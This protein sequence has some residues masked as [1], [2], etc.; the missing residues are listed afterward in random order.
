LR[1]AAVEGKPA[2]NA[3]PPKEA[4]AKST[5]PKPKPRQREPEK[6]PDQEE[7]L[8]R[9]DK[10]GTSNAER[11]INREADNAI[12]IEQRKL[13]RIDEALE[14][15]RR[16]GDTVME[17][18]L[19][20]SRRGILENIDDINV[21]RSTRLEKVGTYEKKSRDAKGTG[22][23]A[24]QQTSKE[25]RQAKRAVAK[26]R[27]EA[28]SA[29]TQINER[30]ARSTEKAKARLEDARQTLDDAFR[31][32]LDDIA[33]KRLTRT[34]A[35]AE[36]ALDTQGEAI[37]QTEALIKTIRE[38][39]QDVD[40]SEVKPIQ[41]EIRNLQKELRSARKQYGDL[42]AKV[43]KYRKAAQYYKEGRPQDARRTYLSTRPRKKVESIKPVGRSTEWGDKTAHALNR[44]TLP[45]GHR[46][47][48]ESVDK[49]WNE[50]AARQIKRLNS[51]IAE[52]KADQISQHREFNRLRRRRNRDTAA[53][54]AN[55]GDRAATTQRLKEAQRDLKT[56]QTE[57]ERIRSGGRA[58]AD[59]TPQRIKMKPNAGKAVAGQKK[60]PKQRAVEGPPEHLLKSHEKNFKQYV[61]MSIG[62]GVSQNDYR[63]IIASR[64]IVDAIDRLTQFT[65]RVRHIAKGRSQEESGIFKKLSR[66][67]DDWKKFEQSNLLAE[68]KTLD[69]EA[70][71]AAFRTKTNETLF[72]AGMEIENILRH[73]E[74]FS[75][76]PQQR[77]ELE[78]I[79]SRI[80]A[81]KGVRDA[82]GKAIGNYYLR[83]L[84]PG[85]AGA[86]LDQTA[87]EEDSTGL[88]AGVAITL[89][90]LGYA[91]RSQI[92]DL[93]HRI[94]DVMSAE[95]KLAKKIIK[96]PS[97]KTKNFIN[98]RWRLGIR[99]GADVTD[100]STIAGKHAAPENL[101]E[102]LDAAQSRPVPDG[103]ISAPEQEASVRLFADVLH[104]ADPDAVKAM[105]SQGPAK[106]SDSLYDRV[107]EI[108]QERI[109]PGSPIGRI[110]RYF[111]YGLGKPQ[112]Y[113]DARR[114]ARGAMAM[115][116]R[117]IT[118][119][120]ESLEWAYDAKGNRV[121]RWNKAEKDMLWRLM[122]G[123]KVTTPLAN[124]AELEKISLTARKMFDQAG[125]W[126]TDLG[127]LSKAKFQ[128]NK[129]K[130][131]T[132]LWAEVEAQKLG[133]GKD[134]VTSITGGHP[135]RIL[136]T[137]SMKRGDEAELSKRL[138]KIT[139]PA[140]PTYAGLRSIMSDVV[141]GTFFKAVASESAWAM[142]KPTYQVL[143]RVASN[144]LGQ[145]SKGDKESLRWLR[146]NGHV[147]Y[148]RFNNAK[149]TEKG[150]R[151]LDRTSRAR[152]FDEHGVSGRRGRSKTF[153]A[154][155]RNTFGHLNGMVV[156]DGIAEDLQM[157]DDFY[158][159]GWL[160]ETYGNFLH[161]WKWGRILINPATH[162]RNMMSNMILS[163]LGGMSPADPRS[164]RA[165]KESA[166]MIY[167]DTG[168][169]IYKRAI[170]KGLIRQGN[171]SGLNTEQR[172]FFANT[173]MR[174]GNPW[175][176]GAL[177][178][179]AGIE[180][181]YQAEE[182]LMKLA[183]V[184]H[185]HLNKGMAVDDAI[186][187]ARRS[188]FDYSEIPP[189]VQFMRKGWSPF[190]TFNYKA[191]PRVMETAV[192]HP[193]RLGKWIALFGTIQA[194]ARD[195]F[196]GMDHGETYA[197]EGDDWRAWENEVKPEYL[198]N[199]KIAGVPLFDK[200]LKLPFID[201][202]GRSQYLDLQFILPWGDFT[203]G[204][205]GKGGLANL[206]IPEDSKLA[207]LRHLPGWIQPQFPFV[208]EAAE[209]LMNKSLFTGQPI[210]KEGDPAK[211]K[212]MFDYLW[213]SVL[214]SI[215]PFNPINFFASD[216]ANKPSGI[217]A[218]KQ[219]DVATAMASIFRDGGYSYNKFV[220]G[221]EKIP[222]YRGRTRT[223]AA[224]L[225]DI[226][227]GIKTTPVDVHDRT[228]MLIS[229]HQWAIRDLKGQL[230]SIQRNQKWTSGQRSA[231]EKEIREQI[232]KHQQYIN[233]ISRFA[234]TIAKN[235]SQ[236]K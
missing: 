205:D 226:M 184:R 144:G 219:G 196:G 127:F 137:R 204:L 79:L 108:I 23:P 71:V 232:Q 17:N 43:T 66:M 103:R 35:V 189:V 213:R 152:S 235:R 151:F 109:K 228:K 169:A 145:I 42:N 25:I 19:L 63:E 121:R 7:L 12:K 155:G 69:T 200:A 167:K 24:D 163:D 91:K 54:D 233:K 122:E 134:Q 67:I 100:A 26:Q 88:V 173:Y 20:A 99:K 222:D 18:N 72:D 4:P 13:D 179:K 172:R 83:A 223:M 149:L 5:Q 55:R 57:L 160:E 181:T 65:N 37:S 150:Q 158:Q 47:S 147:T 119:L 182:D 110:A 56:W 3:P 234:S 104:Q 136:G 125:Q 168:D 170:A 53:I 164:W 29:A 198:K 186:E 46:L 231:R 207:A 34:L 94:A 142:T 10:R 131:I 236:A 203:G 14:E 90:L 197:G 1:H 98:Y 52:L 132:R 192:T 188:L 106:T 161:A 11:L 101:R 202:H 229:N 59:Y 157:M 146:K 193:V 206:L 210:I 165:I 51:R 212:T 111:F 96:N 220:R 16:T 187:H 224:V 95:A 199:T 208:K 85:L 30:N 159:K 153:N 2:V 133:L 143:G 211:G 180:K 141:N 215:T 93:S 9:Q 120:A 77:S 214:P 126:Y 221:L 27:K 61:L 123:Q 78:Y 76:T 41:A 117:A 115:W 87:D 162:S 21:T 62:G 218:L 194:L 92:K 129:G 174:D 105:E 40:K 82:A 39:L 44:R 36:D 118:K 230:S 97:E 154:W 38:S 31:K 124:Q 148:T 201:E 80:T 64:E 190:I 15:A 8:A 113:I 70:E 50:Y 175:R 191:I 139:E 116:D 195:H 68:G 185:L 32:N 225:A 130:Y 171:L 48:G 107:S 49:S 176:R 227:V 183:M 84:T 114:T 89:A 177:E 178:V 217:D 45:A 22:K 81:V 156:L 112:E 209:L 128:E 140:Y 216:D 166:L 135:M 73:P 102:S 74:R 75:I 28:H 86:G 58:Q 33:E 138:T 60:Y 6:M